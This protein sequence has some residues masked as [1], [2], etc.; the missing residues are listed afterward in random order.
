[1]AFHKIKNR[2]KAKKQGFKL[3]NTFLEKLKGEGRSINYYLI[4][5]LLD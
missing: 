2:K 3:G 4:N 5:Y 1:M